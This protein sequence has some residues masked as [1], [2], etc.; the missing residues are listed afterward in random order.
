MIL[1]LS[2]NSAFNSNTSFKI[3]IIEDCIDTRKLVTRLLD[4][5]GIKSKALIG[6][7][8]IVTELL[9]FNPHLIL[10]DINLPNQDGYEICNLLK[11]DSRTKKV[12]IFFLTSK[13]KTM[14]KVKG[15]ELGADDYIVKPFEPAEFI[16]RI[17]RAL[18]R[19]ELYIAY[20][21][22]TIDL[23]KRTVVYN[24]PAKSQNIALSEIEFSLFVYFIQNQN[25]ILTRE[26]IIK[27]VWPDQLNI[28]KR[29]VDVQISSLRK[30]LNDFDTTINS[31]YGKGYELY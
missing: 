2:M 11:N 24:K 8:D 6:N 27:N 21:S 3:L 13:S 12:P 31:I 16:A 5:S 18:Q 19:N 20:K 9:R 1:L 26:E 7:E 23:Q 28:A 29:N 14:D 25:N 10:L 17:K 30:K 4:L 15:F 22:F